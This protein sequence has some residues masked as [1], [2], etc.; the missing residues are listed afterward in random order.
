MLIVIDAQLPIE[1]FERPANMRFHRAQRKPAAQGDGRMGKIFKEGQSQQFVLH[2]RQSKQ[3]L[4][5]YIQANLLL[6]GGTGRR[7]T[8]GS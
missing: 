5:Q 3:H 2:R 8:A 6:R 1:A 7:C 4:F